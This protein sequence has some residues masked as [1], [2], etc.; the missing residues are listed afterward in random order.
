MF[1]TVIKL[2]TEWHHLCCKGMIREELASYH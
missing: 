1:Q 2:F